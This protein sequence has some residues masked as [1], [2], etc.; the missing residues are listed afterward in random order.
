MLMTRINADDSNAYTFDNSL[1][2]LFE[3]V[4]CDF[5]KIVISYVA[6]SSYSI[7]SNKKNHLAPDFL[8]RGQTRQQNIE[9][10]FLV[11]VIDEITVI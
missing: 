5:L 4:Y 7:Y 11:D 1:G 8:V 10:K 3:H 6:K 9:L 2:N